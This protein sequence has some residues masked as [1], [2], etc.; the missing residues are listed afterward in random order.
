MRASPTKRD[1]AL[2]LSALVAVLVGTGLLLETTG[3]MLPVE[4]A[5]PLVVMAS[6]GVLLYFA[7]V[8][9]RTGIFLGA[10]AFLVLSGLVFLFVGSGWGLGRTWPLL[11]T[12]AGL[13]WLAYGFWTFGRL[14][15]NFLVPSVIIVVLSLF[16][17]LFS[18]RIVTVRLTS[19]IAMWWPLLLI[20]GGIALFVAWSLRAGRAKGRRRANRP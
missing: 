10:G 14:R 19:F 11:M 18:F 9:G 13:S 15:I 12:S 20:M 17:A 6:G 16:F 4:W 2:F 8:Q 7:L 5:G 1:D 3:F